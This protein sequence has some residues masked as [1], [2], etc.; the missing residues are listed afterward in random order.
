VVE[1]EMHGTLRDAGALSALF[2]IDSAHA[3]KPPLKSSKQRA[4]T[5]PFCGNKRLVVVRAGPRN[6]AIEFGSLLRAPFNKHLGGLII[7]AT[8]SHY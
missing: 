1:E 3:M 5:L 7:I 2:N 6:R 4:T 8:F